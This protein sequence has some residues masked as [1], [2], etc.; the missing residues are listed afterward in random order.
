MR[1]NSECQRWRLTEAARELAHLGDV[2]AEMVEMSC[3]SLIK[4][5]TA[6]AQQVL[7]QEDKLVDPVTKELDHFVNIL[8]RED[9]SDIQQKALHSTS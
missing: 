4:K 8:M 2:T 6:Y 1:C 3:V 7:V 9:L 5:D